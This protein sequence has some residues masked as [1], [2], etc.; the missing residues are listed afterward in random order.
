[1]NVSANMSLHG[2]IILQGMES[3]YYVLNSGLACV[4]N[5]LC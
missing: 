5:A 2:G 1:M 3:F 4:G